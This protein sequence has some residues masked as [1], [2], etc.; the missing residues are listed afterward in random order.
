MKIPNQGIP[1]VGQSPKVEPAE[2]EEG[3]LTN[4][5]RLR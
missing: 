5:Q 3:F 1:F 2:Y 4:R